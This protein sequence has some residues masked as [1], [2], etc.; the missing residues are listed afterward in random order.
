[1]IRTYAYRGHR[2]CEADVSLEV[3]RNVLQ[4]EKGMVWMDFDKPTEEEVKLL[5]QFFNF[6]P[7]AI[8][9]CVNVRHHPK[10][11]DYE[12]YLFMIFHAPDLSQSG[13]QVK[14][15]EI[16]IFLGK[17]FIVT[18]HVENIPSI[19]TVRQKCE[20]NSDIVMGRGSDFFLQ[21]LLDRIMENYEPLVEDLAEE[22]SWAE[23]E[24]FFNPDDKF[25]KAIFGLKKDILY[26][27]R[28]MAPQ[29]DTILQLS[30]EGSWLISEKARLY[31][32]DVYDLLYRIM[33]LLETYRDLV[34][35]TVDAYLIVDNNRMNRV[36]KDLTMMTAVMLPLTFITGI[37]GMNFKH[38]P[39]LDWKL[40]YAFV[41]GIMLLTVALQLIIMK[42]KK[43]F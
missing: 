33:D 1:M 19:Q 39:E 29:R 31:F 7:L 5:S 11:D 9:D 32:K 15:N 20:K 2:Q 8:E 30:K 18:H 34:N 27:R 14:T 36:M 43:Y 22:V 38:M 17:H 3:V 42:R 28:I 35:S 12:D 24:V 13:Q 21:T 37:Y 23:E 4:E 25:L 40:G 6:H 41:W 10:I 16:D 26:V